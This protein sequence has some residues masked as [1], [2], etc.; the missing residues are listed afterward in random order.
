MD[1]LVAIG[2]DRAR[3][4]DALDSQYI[5]VKMR[6]LD[7]LIEII[8]QINI[9]NVVIEKKIKPA[10]D[11]LIEKHISSPAE[12]DIALIQNAKRALW[13][14]EVRELSDNKE[15]LKFLQDNLENTENGY[16]Y[17]F[18]AMDYLV[19]IGNDRAREILEEK[20]KEDA[21]HSKSQKIA[22]RLLVSI[23]KIKV[24]QRLENLEAVS[25][26]QELKDLISKRKEEKG[27]SSSN[28]LIWLIRQLEKINDPAAIQA[29]RDIWQDDKYELEY[30]NEAQEGL[31][32][33]KA[34]KPEEEKMFFFAD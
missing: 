20:L 31:I 17:L 14:I 33:L 2:N 6:S 25:R 11:F 27:F 7:L 28:I 5:D 23:E 1:Y 30:R 10:V 8:K 29:L 34:I 32:R 19:A 4:L 22:D 24:I 3:L 21:K 15:R 13:H 9:P 12:P 18:E 16:Y 26:T